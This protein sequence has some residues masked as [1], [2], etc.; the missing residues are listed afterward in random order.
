MTVPEMKS[1]FYPFPKVA[2]PIKKQN[3]FYTR[4]SPAVL[5]VDLWYEVTWQGFVGLRAAL[6]VFAFLYLLDCY[7]Y[8]ALS[9]NKQ[10]NHWN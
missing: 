3:V 9:N 10:Q 2:W 7:I 6:R 4:K 8:G 1:T 5:W